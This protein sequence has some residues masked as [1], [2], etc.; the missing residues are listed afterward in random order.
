MK[1]TPDGYAPEAGRLSRL[2]AAMPD[3]SASEMPV[4]VIREYEPQIGRAHV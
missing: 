1:P 4:Y 2:M 3:F